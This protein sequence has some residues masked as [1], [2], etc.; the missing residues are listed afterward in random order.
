[1]GPDMETV[2]GTWEKSGRGTRAESVKTEWPSHVLNVHGL[3]KLNI[4]GSKYQ[5]CEQVSGK[6]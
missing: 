6:K 5:E 2:Y 1:M 3:D 4:H